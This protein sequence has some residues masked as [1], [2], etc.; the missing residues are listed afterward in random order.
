[1]GP[2]GNQAGRIFRDHGI[3]FDDRLLQTPRLGQDNRQFFPGRG[4]GGLEHQQTAGR[5]NRIVGVATGKKEIEGTE[6][7]VGILLPQFDGP[8]KMRDGP[9]SPLLRHQIALHQHLADRQ[10][11]QSCPK[12]RIIIAA[13]LRQS[14]HRGSSFPSATGPG[15]GVEHL[16]GFDEVGGNFQGLAGITLRQLHFTEFH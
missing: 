1:M 15:N 11:A 13:L 3:K 9:T 16:V 12:F 7:D 4:V 10:I 5:G 2:V 8:T 6:Q 14:Q